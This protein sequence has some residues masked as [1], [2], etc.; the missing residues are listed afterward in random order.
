MFWS[1]QTNLYVE[2]WIGLKSLDTAGRVKYIS[3]PGNHLRIS[4]SDAKE[5]IV[6]YL[7]GES[8]EKYRNKQFGASRV[9]EMQVIHQIDDNGLMAMIVEGSSCE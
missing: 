2:D 4:N 9:K 6:P 1:S 8:S 3:V 7:E 5:Y